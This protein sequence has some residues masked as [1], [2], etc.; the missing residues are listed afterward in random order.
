MKIL[1][2]LLIATLLSLSSFGQS[3]Y[4]R[5]SLHVLLKTAKEDSNKIELLAEL[6]FTFNMVD[7]DS[8]SYYLHRALA[9]SKKINFETGIMGVCQALAGY[10]DSKSKRDSSIF[11]LMMCLTTARELK[12][13]LFIAHT[14]LRLSYG[15]WQL[16]SIDIAKSI[17]YLDS[18]FLYARKDTIVLKEVFQRKAEIAIHQNNCPVAKYFLQKAFE[19]TSEAATDFP[20]QITLGSFFNQSGQSDSAIA[21]FNSMI[22]RNKETP[23]IGLTFESYLY[24][25]ISLAYLKLKK[26][27]PAIENA[28]KGLKLAVDSHLTKERLDNLKIL[29]QIYSSKKDYEKALDYYKQHREYT[30][31]LNA[32]ILKSSDAGFQNQLKAERNQQQLILLEKENEKQK[33]VRNVFVGGFA[34]MVVFTAVFFRQRNKIKKGKQRS[35]ELLLNIL[36]SEVAEELKLKG[37]ADARQ[38]NEVTVMF[39]D[40]KGFT[41]IA[42]KLSPTQLVNEIHTCFKAFDDIITKHNIEK[43]KTIGDAYMCAGGLPVANKTNAVDVVFAALEI[44]AFM[45]KRND[46]REKS[47]LP[48]FEIRLGVNTGPVVAGIVGVKKFAYDIWGDTVNIASRMESSGEAGKVNISGSTYEMV[49]NKFNCV[50]RGKIKAKNKGVIDMYFVESIS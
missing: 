16:S 12:D 50:H 48:V 38:F 9:L 1:L 36:P 34:L 43:I 20:L 41:Q 18:A 4:Q 2:T 29:Y 40:F 28:E 25:Q 17:A 26:Y 46:E 19:L 8:C 3:Q 37:T 31:S 33:L 21:V 14:F 10:H 7:N 45:E 22:E 24:G 39:T 47:G 27:K 15:V 44:Q 49:K 30:D 6:A 23:F 42:E 5:D 11:Y 32:D 35:D 13:S